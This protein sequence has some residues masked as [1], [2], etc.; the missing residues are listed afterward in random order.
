MFIS[1]RIQ[2]IASREANIN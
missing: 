2:S 1:S